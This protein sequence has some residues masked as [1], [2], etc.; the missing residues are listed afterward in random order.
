MKT[1]Q[2]L[3]QVEIAGNV[4]DIHRVTGI[5]HDIPT[6][7]I[8]ERMHDGFY[9]LTYNAVAIPDLTKVKGITFIRKNETVSSSV[10]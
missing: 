1:P 3:L 10:G 7:F 5:K 6:I 4:I 9:R 2:V 8:V